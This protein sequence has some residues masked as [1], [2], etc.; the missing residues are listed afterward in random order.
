MVSKILTTL[1]T[2]CL[3][4]RRARDEGMHTYFNVI[5]YITVITLEL[6]QKLLIIFNSS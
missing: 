4:G 6:K 5:F 3:W 1:K 2:R